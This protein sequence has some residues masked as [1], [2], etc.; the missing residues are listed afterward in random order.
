MAKR[1]S[2]VKKAPQRYGWED[3]HEEFPRAERCIDVSMP[4]ITLVKINEV[5]SSVTGNRW[6][7]TYF[8]QRPKSPVV[9]GTCLRGKGWGWAS[10][11]GFGESVR[12]V[13]CLTVLQLEH[14]W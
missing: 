4:A 7:N 5:K 13:V 11:A 3:G 9:L 8:F 14:S 12:V 6:S 1:Q 2:R 10:E